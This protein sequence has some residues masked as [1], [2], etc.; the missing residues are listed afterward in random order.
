MSIKNYAAFISEQNKM[1]KT[2]NDT[3]VESTYTYH[4]T[5]APAG[6]EL[7]SGYGDIDH[8]AVNAHMKSLGVPAEHIKAI[9]AHLKTSK[10]QDSDKLKNGVMSKHGEYTVHSYSDADSGKTKFVVNS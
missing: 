1:L 4:D 10:H 5:K 6:A 9:S 3:L 7:V 2:I 8:K